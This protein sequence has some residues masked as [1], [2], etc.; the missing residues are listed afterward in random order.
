MKTITD[1]ARLPLA[2]LPTPLEP[3]SNL[4]RDLGTSIWMKRDDY[5]GLGGGG[6]KAR[7]LEF[8]MAEAVEQ[9]ADVVITTG[10]H[11]SNHARM[12][13]AT[14]CR[15]GMQTVLVLRGESP[16]AWQGNL[17][18]DRLFG[19]EFEFLPRDEYFDL[20]AD[21]FEAQTA[22]AR[23]RGLQ[24]YIIPVG[25]G[26]PLGALGYVF[27]VEET[28]RQWA[29]LDLPDP[30]F[31]VLAL[32]SG[33][34]QAGLELGVRRWWPNTR[35]IGISVSQLKAAC[36]EKVATL[37]SETAELLDAP[38]H[39]GPE[40]IW[41]EDGYVGPRGYGF[42]SDG[43]FAAIHRL[44]RTE[45]VILDPVYTGKAMD[46]LLGLLSAGV[47]GSEHRVIFLHTG[48]A[49]SLFSFADAVIRGT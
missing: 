45:G 4:S 49:P 20:I 25:G 33:G 29:D 24:P 17:L 7:K 42:P 1:F 22:R 6:N 12:V 15:L 16:T 14:A 30:D 13:A 34:T 31:I 9:K 40:D 32:G 3:M 18:L 21:R 26:S 23:A 37:A 5:T 48:G 46:G 2:F 38:D 47:I 27:A 41:V 10:G 44:A 8:L 36:Q 39:F 19:A 11:Q 35:V 28:V 43:A